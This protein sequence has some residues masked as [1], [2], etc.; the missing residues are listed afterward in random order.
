VQPPGD[1]GPATLAL[2]EPAYEHGWDAKKHNEHN[3]AGTP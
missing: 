3:T 2:A 1:R